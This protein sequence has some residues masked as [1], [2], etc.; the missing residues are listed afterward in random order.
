VHHRAK[1][2]RLGKLLDRFC[3]VAFIVAIGCALAAL[4]GGLGYRLGWWHYRVGIVTIAY[5]FW[6]AGATAAASAVAIVLAALRPDARR[7]LAMAVAGFAIAVL[8]AW[9]PWNLRE[10]ARALPPIHD[11]TTDP[12]NPPQFVGVAK[13]RGPGDHPVAYDGPK[14]AALQKKAYPDLVPLVLQAPRGAV[15]AAAQRVLASMGL[16]LVGAD[17]AQ[18]RLEATATS[19]LFGFRDDVVVRI[20]EVPGGTRVDVRSKSRVGVHDLGM[21][22]KRIR[23]FL[24]K[25]KAAE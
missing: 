24:A 16:E 13:L 25:L 4:G 10:T 9:I 2:S 11:I 18:G 1:G 8:T 6:V 15:F 17:P 23:E 20:A 5:V 21:N 22:A 3:L 19:L 14:V 12:L 7:A